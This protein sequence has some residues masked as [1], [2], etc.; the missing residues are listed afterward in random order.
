MS[1]GVEVEESE[2]S[3]CGED[4]WTCPHV[5]GQT[6][7]GK[8]MVPVITKANFFEVSVVSR[9]DFNDARF[10]SQGLPRAE[11]EA[12]I[13][14]PLLPGDRPICNRCTTPCPGLIDNPRAIHG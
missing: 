4:P 12:A 2:C 9:P 14:R 8:R 5:P 3:I 11:V 1:V 6:Y 7:D 10:M 13:G